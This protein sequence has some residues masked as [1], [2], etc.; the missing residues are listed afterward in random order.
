MH[1]YK[2]QIYVCIDLE[3]MCMND[4]MPER[5]WAAYLAAVDNWFGASRRCRDL[6]NGTPR[7]SVL[8]GRPAGLPMG[9]VLQLWLMR[10]SE[11]MNTVETEENKIFRC[12]M[13]LIRKV[14]DQSRRN[15]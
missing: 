5:I 9:A 3:Y 14:I 6:I 13:I 15:Y 8:V 11:H 7:E 1:V 10:M 12:I 4:N 2:I